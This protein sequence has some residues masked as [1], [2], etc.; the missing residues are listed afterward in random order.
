MHS[1]ELNEAISYKLNDRLHYIVL[2]ILQS[3]CR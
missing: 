2:V 3:T 1:F